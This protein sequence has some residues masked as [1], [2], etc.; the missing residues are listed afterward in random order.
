M[1]NR[2][3][4]IALFLSRLLLPLFYRWF[5]LVRL[6]PRLHYVTVTKGGV[7]SEKDE[8]EDRSLL[9]R[10]TAIGF[11]SKVVF[12]KLI[13]N[14]KELMDNLF[15]ELNLWKISPKFCWKSCF[16]KL[17][18]KSHNRM[19]HY[20]SAGIVSYMFIFCVWKQNWTS[21]QTRTNNESY[22][23]LKSDW[24]N[25]WDIYTEIYPVLFIELSQFCQTVFNIFG[26]SIIFR[27]ITL[28]FLTQIVSE[29]PIFP[30][31]RKSNYASLYPTHSS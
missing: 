2:F 1:K 31:V 3:W 16:V 11:C 26:H 7:S 15:E 12:P 6:I 18:L 4:K 20:R 10:T 23:A 28:N 17:N 29:K 24:H 9:W 13:Q 19:P 22:L 5:V 27:T 30:F 8:W 25:G 21:K 14:I